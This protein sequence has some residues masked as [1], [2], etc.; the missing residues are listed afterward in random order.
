MNNYCI[1]VTPQ[2]EEQIR[3]IAYYI[4]VDI[5]EPGAAEVF[6]DELQETFQTI[7]S[8]PERQFL[9]EDEPWHSEGIRKIKV[10][11][12]MVYFWIDIENASV[13]IIGV[14]YSKRDLTRFL[15]GLSLE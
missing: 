14:C 13:K 2:A 9:V 15:K 12:Y 7:S 1:I 4:A 3:D 6:V 11:N 8:N 5:Q 10:R